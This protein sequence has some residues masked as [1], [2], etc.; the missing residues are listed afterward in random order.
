MQSVINMIKAETGID[1]QL[2]IRSASEFTFSAEGN[3][4]EALRAFASK[5]G[6]KNITGEYDAETDYT[7]VWFSAC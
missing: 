2:T 4:L 6:G 1:A 5:I 3:A 7:C